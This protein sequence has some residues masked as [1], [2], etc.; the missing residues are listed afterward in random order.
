MSDHRLNEV[1]IFDEVNRESAACRRFGLVAPEENIGR[2]ATS[3]LLPIDEAR[4]PKQSIVAELAN[5]GPSLG[6]RT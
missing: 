1:A 3:D 6:L 5:I 2:F 4:L